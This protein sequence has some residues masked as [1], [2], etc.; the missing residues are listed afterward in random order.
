LSRD[1]SEDTVSCAS[2]ARVGC[3]NVLIVTYF[4]N[5]QADS[6]CNVTRVSC[7]SVVIIAVDVC[8][9]TFSSLCI[10]SVDCAFVSI[11]TKNWSDNTF[12]RVLVARRWEAF[13][14]SLAVDWGEHTAS[15]RIAG[16]NSTSVI[17][18]TKNW[19]LDEISGQAIAAV[20][21]AFVCTRERFKIV[22]RRADASLN[23]IASVFCA[24]IGVTANDWSVNA[25]SVI[26]R[27]HCACVIVI[28][29][30]SNVLAVSC[31]GVAR[32][33]CACI[34]VVTIFRIAIDTV[35]NI[36]SRDLTQVGCR[37]DWDRSVLANSVY[38]SVCSASVIV[39]TDDWSVHTSFCNIASVDSASIVV[40]ANVVGVNTS[41]CVVARVISASVVVIAADWSVTA[42]SRGRIAIVNCA[43]IIV[44]A[45]NRFLVKSSVNG[46][47]P[48]LAFVNACCILCDKINRSIL[49]SF[50][51]VAGVSCA[52]IMVIAGDYIVMDDSGCLIAIIF[53][54]SI[55]VI[56]VLVGVLA[57][58]ARIASINGARISIVTNNRSRNTSFD[59]VTRVFGT[60]VCI[61]AADWGVNTKTTVEIA[62]VSST[63]VVVIAIDIMV[64]AFSRVHIA[65]NGLAVL[66][67][68]NNRSEY[69]VSICARISCAEIVVITYFF[70]ILATSN[71]I[72]RSDAA[73]VS[74]I[75]GDWLVLDSVLNCAEISGASVVVVKL[76]ETQRSV[77]ASRNSIARVDS[78]RIVVITVDRSVNTFCFIFRA[79][80]NGANVVI[81]TVSSSNV[82]EYASCLRIARF[83]SAR[84]VVV[85]NNQIMVNSASVAIAIVSCASVVIVNIDLGINTFSR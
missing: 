40:I 1:I 57:S 42:L 26:A 70:G 85:A 28:A 80:V 12:S 10:A 55:V 63:C 60:F 38:A 82:G 18:V 49:A 15:C 23:G 2:I 44:I 5:M 64:D 65:R 73:F 4:R 45:V 52:R 56:N 84:I 6:T 32:I 81:I 67:L 61:S 75:T 59:Y 43:S 29:I 16:V 36:A 25:V 69:T 11:V 48:D 31:G 53:C 74:V 14:S 13:V 8:V 71:N 47:E 72:A 7:A 68:A 79:S 78:A 66:F 58:I 3:A 30:L 77:L 22:F 24:R 17:V 34:V 83:V 33:D 41:S 54:A 51:H 50:Y 39:V 35:L 9:N 21:V 76:R 37:W 62:R 46:A 20:S 19:T 27:V